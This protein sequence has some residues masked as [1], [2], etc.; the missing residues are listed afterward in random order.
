MTFNEISN[1]Y[2]VKF[3]SPDQKNIFNLETV[4]YIQWFYYEPDIVVEFVCSN[5]NLENGW[6][7]SYAISL[8]PLKYYKDR[9]IPK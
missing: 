5:N 2:L 9:R 6:K 3:G 1:Q 4:K 7:I 8:N